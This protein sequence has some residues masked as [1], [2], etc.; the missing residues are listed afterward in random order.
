MF[1]NFSSLE[2]LVFLSITSFASTIFLQ[3]FLLKI[4]KKLKIVDTP[5]PRKQKKK[6]LVRIGGIAI[7]F[8]Y[9]ISLLILEFFTQ[10][11]VLN[12]NNLFILSISSFILFLL[13]FIDDL[14]NI[15]P[16]IRLFIQ[17]TISILVWNTGIR[18]ESINISWLNI[19]II[20][21]N[22]FLSIVLTSFWLVGITNAIN[23]ID[24]LDGLASGITGFASIGISTL[25]FQNGQLLA[26]YLSIALAGSCFGF[27]RLNFFPA[28][29]LMGDGGS[30]FIGFNIAIISLLTISSEKNPIGFFTPLILLIIPISDMT[31]V[32]FSRIS[33]GLSPFLPDR[34]H[35]HHRL[36][37][38]GFSELGSV[39]YIYGLSQLFTVIAICL[40]SSDNGIYLLFLLASFFM[41]FFTFIL[42]KKVL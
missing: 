7:I 35:I 16:F 28:K 14:R 5:S 3:P 2:I 36:I 19:P 39:V 1:F 20:D 22:V 4:G 42:A 34:N 37:K 13:G 41:S 32:I 17:I 30:Y 33:K 8:G 6:S 40:G 10:F 25:A 9:F 23:W 26:A 11:S 15:S 18:I 38:L 12:D 29:I 31:Y 24:G 21:L 27:L